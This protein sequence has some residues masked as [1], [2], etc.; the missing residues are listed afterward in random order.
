M[1]ASLMEINRYSHRQSD[2]LHL[3]CG[4][5]Y[6]EDWVNVD[7]SGAVGPDVEHNLDRQPWPF[8]S[9]AF[10]HCEARHVFEHLDD[11]IG[12]FEELGRVLKP[13]G[14][15][16]WVY[17]IGHTRFEDP[18]HQHFWGFWTPETLCGE[19]EHDHETD[20]PFHIVEKVVRWDAGGLAGLYARAREW[21]E[22]PGPWL[23][24]VPGLYGEIEVVMRYDG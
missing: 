1:E 16:R 13:A 22:G 3:G 11:P 18:T 2:R 17:P 15:V 7:I 19:R 6:R 21:R 9:D 8:P 4:E 23:S 10:E 20:L 5:D 14:T 12:A 24:Q